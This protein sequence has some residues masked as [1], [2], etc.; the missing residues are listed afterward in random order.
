[1]QGQ[2]GTCL[3]AARCPRQGVWVQEWVKGREPA[4]TPRSPRCQT[5]S[6]DPRMDSENGAQ[7]IQP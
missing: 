3:R 6:E 7:T 1:M 5:G 4:R 2:R